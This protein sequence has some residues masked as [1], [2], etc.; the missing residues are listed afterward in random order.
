MEGKDMKKYW[1]DEC[2][3]ADGK[4]F[5]RGFELYI[6]EKEAEIIVPS[7]VPG[8]PESL[9][10][11]KIPLAQKTFAAAHENGAPV[12]VDDGETIGEIAE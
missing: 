1:V 11:E 9:Y 5:P 6:Y 2:I 4:T 10:T 7:D 8:D 12:H 3:V